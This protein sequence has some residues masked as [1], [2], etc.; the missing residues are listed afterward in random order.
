MNFGNVLVIGNSGVGKS[1][2]INAVLGKNVAKTGWGT[3]GTTGKLDIYESDDVPFRIIDT[4]GFEPSFIKEH[5]AINAVKKWSKD[6]AKAEN[7]DHQIN[8]IWFCVEGTT[9]KLF[10]QTIKNLSRATSMWESVPVIVVI[11]KSYSEPDRKNN[12]QMVYNAFARQKKFAKNLHSV[13]PVVAKSFV[14]NDTAIAP[15]VGITELIDDTN[16]VMP[17]GIKAG[18]ADINAF[19]LKRK[20]VLAQS[21]V[22][23]SVAAGAVIGAVPIPFAD[24]AIL[25]PLEICEI[26]ALASV[27]GINK[28]EKSKRLCNSMVEVGTV[29]VAAKTIISG[30]KSIPGLNIATGILNAVIAGTIITAIG[31]GSTYVFEKIYLGEKSID[32]IEWIKN[33]MESKFSNQLIDQVNELFKNGQITNKT[34]AKDIGKILSK[35]VSTKSTVKIEK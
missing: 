11:T 13:I 12:I 4:I 15:P 27:Y 29:S 18:E 24:T 33:I 22:V 26:N 14:I 3:S 28:D 5:Q 31:E 34:K 1:T 8:V 30:F 2:L 20:R 23:A 19:K 25:A 10:S 7:E 6:S 21:V 9:S 16:N 35:S 17:E 32:D